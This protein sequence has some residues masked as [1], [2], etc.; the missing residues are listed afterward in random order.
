MK[1]LFVCDSWNGSSA[2]SLRDELYT[3]PDLEMDDIAHDHFAIRG[4]S[5]VVRLANRILTRWRQKGLS[6]EIDLKI[7]KFNPDVLFVCKGPLVDTRVIRKARAKRIIT[8]NRFPDCSPHAHG[9]S[10]KQAIGEYDLVISTKAYHPPNWEKIYGY[11]NRCICVPHGYSPNAHQWDTP[12][13][14]QDVDLVMA[15][16][17]RPQYQTLLSALSQTLDTSNMNVLIVGPG[18]KDHRADL[19]A[20]WQFYDGVHGRGYGQVLRRGKIA[21]APVHREMTCNGTSQ[22]GDEDTARTYE[23]AAAHCF[24]LHCRTDYMQTVYSE[25]DEVPMWADAEELADKVR[26][27]LPRPEVRQRMAEAAHRRAVP[28]YSQKQRATQM[29][30]YLREILKNEPCRN[31]LT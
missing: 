20:H 25:S 13:R 16:S 22:P 1:I 8:V 21:I 3:H 5:L 2:R 15:A 7:S 14:N 30:D 29:I 24:F 31:L 27:F 17:W 26:F 18:W 10:L 19:P 23:L 9:A 6:D 12:P 28:A 4:R 11:H